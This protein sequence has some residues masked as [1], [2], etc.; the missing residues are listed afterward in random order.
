MLVKVG[1][2]LLRRTILAGE[3][4]N[5]YDKNCGKKYKNRKHD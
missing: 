5:Q 1:I 3:K 2:S 4:G